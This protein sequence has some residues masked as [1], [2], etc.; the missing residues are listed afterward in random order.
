MFNQY[1][2]GNGG[3]HLRNSWGHNREWLEVPADR[4]EDIDRSFYIHIKNLVKH[5]LY[6]D[7]EVLC[8]NYNWDPKDKPKYEFKNGCVDGNNL[9]MLKDISFED[10]QARCDENS[11]CVGIEYFK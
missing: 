4:I 10:C 11:K 7:D 8:E 2:D 1:S 6:E 3:L 5:K 9:E